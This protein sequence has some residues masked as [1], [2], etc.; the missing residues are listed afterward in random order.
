M[1]WRR[2]KAFVPVDKVAVGGHIPVAGEKKPVPDGG[3]L[4][5]LFDIVKGRLKKAGWAVVHFPEY[6]VKFLL[7][8][9]AAAMVEPLYRI[10]QAV[11]GPDHPFSCC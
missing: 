9:N 11:E 8:R 5:R 1:N 4:F 7:G 10:Q 2:I 6:N 3:D